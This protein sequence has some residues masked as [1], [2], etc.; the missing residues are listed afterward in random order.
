MS[1][2]TSTTLSGSN[3]GARLLGGS[4]RPAGPYDR[5]DSPD[6][7]SD[8]LAALFLGVDGVDDGVES[9]D[10]VTEV[11]LKPSSG[12]SEP[13]LSLLVLGNLPVHAAGWASQYARDRHR[14]TGR[15]VGLL[16]LG[17]ESAR[18]EVFGVPGLS[19]RA[20][21]E[22]PRA[23]ERLARLDADLI[24][25][26]PE[27]EAGWIGGECEAATMTI[28]AG[29]DDPAIV[30]A[31][32]SIKSIAQD[33]PP[34]EAGPVMRI[35]VAGAHGAVA[36]EAAN[37]L[38]QAAQRFLGLTVESDTPVLRIDAGVSAELYHG[39]PPAW[40]DVPDLLRRMLERPV[41]ADVQTRPGAGD[42]FEPRRTSVPAGFNAEGG[43][44]T[45][46]KLENDA[47]ADTIDE[48]PSDDVSSHTD[49]TAH[50]RTLPDGLEPVEVSCPYAH[51]VKLAVDGS[52]VLHA[53]AWAADSE[54]ASA[55]VRDLVVVSSWLRDHAELIAVVM[56]QRLAGLPSVRHL[57]LRDARGALGLAQGELRLHVEAP[58]VPILLDLN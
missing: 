51:E 9:A 45:N 34:D 38:A 37:K 56:G 3:N 20:E 50:Q 18:L 14:D 36:G 12:A 32:Q 5:A 26:L 53:V 57:V 41:E 22:L 31:Y 1:D 43:E 24:V 7:V 55:A 39:A 23:L 27:A 30:R 4:D 11:E 10:P 46:V 8:D 58:N 47:S 25:R 44:V 28:L 2:H 52:G 17:D 29:A 35:A 54:R 15:A 42:R 49:A 40:A 6:G 13:A 21:A 48:H 33:L 16:S 19:G